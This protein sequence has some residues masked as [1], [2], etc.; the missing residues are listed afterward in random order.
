MPELPQHRPVDR[1]HLFPGLGHPTLSDSVTTPGRLAVSCTVA[2]SIFRNHVSG[3]PPLRPELGN[4]GGVTWTVTSKE[5]PH[6]GI[7]QHQ[8]GKESKDVPIGVN[9]NVP[10]LRSGAVSPNPRI[11]RVAPVGE[12]NDPF[13]TVISTH[14]LESREKDSEEFLR[15]N[16][17]ERARARDQVTRQKKDK[18]EEKFKNQKFNVAEEK[19][20]SNALDKKGLTKGGSYCPNE[21]GGNDRSGKPHRRGLTC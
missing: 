18:I 14:D 10:R 19:R 17:E 1:R 5:T 2:S 11:A 4:V 15:T 3:L 13:T 6:T 8:E 9:I 21:A 12:G 7:D 16:P 20:I